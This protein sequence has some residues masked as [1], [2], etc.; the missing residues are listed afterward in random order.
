MTK[1]EVL[2]EELEKVLKSGLISQEIFDAMIERSEVE[3]K[4]VEEEPKKTTTE[5]F[6]E[7][8]MSDIQ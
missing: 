7:A 4:D 6:I 5:E 3:G 2:K 8:F 1:Y